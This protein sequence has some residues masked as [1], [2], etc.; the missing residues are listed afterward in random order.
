MVKK[1]PVML[2][3]HVQRG[4]GH[5]NSGTA[6]SM[7]SRLSESGISSAK[8]RIFD[9]FFQLSRCSETFNLYCRRI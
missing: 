5:G 7:W 6:R 9:F 8:Y 4:R 2:G 1:N 3:K